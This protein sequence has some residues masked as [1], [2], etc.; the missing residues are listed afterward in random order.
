MTYFQSFLLGFVQGLTEYL[1]ISSSAHL[2]LLP[3]LMGFP[4]PGLAFDVFL[5]LGTLGSTLIYF[6]KDWWE[7]LC[8]LKPRKPH[9]PGQS[10]TPK[11][12]SWK[13]VVLGTVPVLAVG[14]VVHPWVSTVLRGNEVI[15]ASLSLGGVA[16]WLIDAR[17]KQNQN[18]TQLS[19]TAA[20]WIG[21]LQCLALIPGVSRSGSTIIGGRLL[22]LDRA[23]A[24]RFS[25]LLS[26]PA[27]MAALAFEL[28]HWSEFV[29]LGHEI[30]WGCLALGALSAFVSGCLAIGGVLYLVRSFSY[31]SFALY[32]VALAGIVYYFL[33]R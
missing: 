3:R 21:L 12:L 18:L 16:L 23:S 9:N 30:G 2:I 1:P 25:F 29:T 19:Y 10:G 17:C 8:S 7:M 15:V 26:A 28:R 27:V 32:R 6:R 13:H 24:A 11:G 20:G 5:H 22:G 31:L 14:A 33:V 4:D